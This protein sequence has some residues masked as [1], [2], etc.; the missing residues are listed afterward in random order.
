MTPD[1]AASIARLNLALG[2]Q[3]SEEEASVPVDDLRRVLDAFPAERAVGAVRE[4]LIEECAA[5]TGLPID[6]V[7][8]FV[9]GTICT[10]D[11][12]QSARLI[13]TASRLGLLPPD[14]PPTPT[15]T[16]DRRAVAAPDPEYIAGW[17][18]GLDAA[19]EENL[20]TP[21]VVHRIRA[22]RKEQP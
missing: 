20:G 1:L 22:L 16:P 8:R 15:P 7:R 21:Y 6:L 3:Q 11:N 14:A 18:A 5:G 19:A 17:N 10:L 12:E 4:R 2:A 9:D 13:P